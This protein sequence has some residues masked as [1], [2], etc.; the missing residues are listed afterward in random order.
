MDMIGA[1]FMEDVD[2][3]RNPSAD[4]CADP[5]RVCFHAFKTVEAWDR[6]FHQALGW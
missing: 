5:A 2:V 3:L 1:G 6:C 4:S